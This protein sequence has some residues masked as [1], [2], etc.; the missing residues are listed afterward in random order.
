MGKLPFR[1]LIIILCFFSMPAFGKL[2][3]KDST[4]N[5]RLGK[6]MS[7]LRSDK[8][9]TFREALMSNLFEP[10]TTD[11]PNLGTQ[12]NSVWLKFSIE[13]Q[14]SREFFLLEVAYPILDQVDLYKPDGNGG[15]ILVSQGESKKFSARGYKHPAY[16]FDLAIP[17]GSSETYYLRIKSTEHLILPVS[18]SEPM[19]L[20]EVLSQ[21]DLLSGIYMGIIIIMG[22][23]NLFLFFSVRDRSYIYYSI[24]VFLAGLTQVG[25]KGY[26]YQYLWPD[27]PYFE[28]KSVVMFASICGIAAL[29][30][31]RNFLQIKN[32]YPKIDM[33][34]KA[35]V[36]VFG[37][38]VL[39]VFMGY[40]LLGFVVMQS[41]TTV[42]LV[43][44]FFISM[45]IMT[46]GYRPA[47]FFFI[48]WTAL[49]TGSI[50]FLLK[51]YGVLPYN[52]I[53]SSAAQAASALEMALLSFALAD[54]IN[55]L[56]KE[57]DQSRLAA[58]RIAKENGRIIKEQ[59]VMLEIKVN[60]R[61]EELVQKNMEIA[62]TLADLQQ[63]QMQLVESEKMASLGQLTAGIAHEINNPINFVTGNIGPLKRDVE[64]LFQTIDTFEQL[65]VQDG[66]AAEKSEHIASYKEEQD[67]DYLKMEIN[68]LLKG[69]TEG[70]NRTAEI[71]KSLRIFSRLDEDDLKFADINE[72]L[73][74]TIIIVN[75][76][77]ENKKIIKKY[78]DLPLVS[79]YPGKLNQV[80]LN[81]IS[82]A[83]F[84]ITEKFGDAPGGELT[85]ES[86]RVDDLH[87]AVVITDNGTGMSEETKRKIFE[88]FFTTKDVGQ[89]TGLGMSIAFNT[90]QKHN[91]QIVV[92][93]EVGRG[94][95]FKL[96]IPINEPV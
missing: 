48:A 68:H 79:C 64:V 4:R 61:T 13:N 72:G 96:I 24:Y 35:L 73:E 67:F 5:A 27:N 74:S 34:I 87:I 50:V 3:L 52:I 91:G 71:V 20:W 25:I 81:I 32:N 55:T 63:A 26:N 28:S 94:T 10:N 76:L 51:D 85:V 16:I 43:S 80:F 39:L 59:N 75:N 8:E 9:V 2:I 44:V 93:S 60:E 77:L 21:Q 11:I 17:T 23:Y 41:T 95:S 36:F 62:R 70:A 38:S 86:Y 92:D 37:V 46:R 54:K 6:H 53:T 65:A 30:F 83:L 66:A 47:I 89:G 29:L 45:Y 33:L 15:Y 56:K 40:D 49:L 78:G 88:P 14:S 31:T 22:V 82:N 12:V 19:G 84:A 7:V 18:I 58:L 42:F 1:L 57:K 90:I 69:I